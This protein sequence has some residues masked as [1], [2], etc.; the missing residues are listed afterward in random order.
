ML[1]YKTITDLRKIAKSEGMKSSDRKSE[2]QIKQFFLDLG[3]EIVKDVEE[4]I[5]E[6]VV[7]TLRFLTPIWCHYL[8]RNYKEGLYQPETK[9]EYAAL[10]PY[11]QGE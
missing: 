5:K 8:N 2:E 9:E 3:E 6:A 11:A 7:K 10:K 1:K 4:E